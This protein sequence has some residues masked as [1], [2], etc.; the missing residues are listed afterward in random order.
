MIAQVVGNAYISARMDASNL[1]A[2]A[3]VGLLMW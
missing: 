1:S 3:R 2:L